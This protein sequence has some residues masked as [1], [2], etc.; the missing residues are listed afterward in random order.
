MWEDVLPAFRFLNRMNL[1][2]VGE[3]QVTLAGLL[4]AI[5]AAIVAV[6]AVRTLPGM[7]DVYVLSRF[8]MHDG[9]RSALVT[10]VRYFLVI[11]GVV[12][13]CSR[14]GATWANLHWIVAALGVGLGFGLQEIV[15]NLTSGLLLLLDGRIRPLD[16]VTV[17]DTSGRVTSI[18][19]LAT[20]VTDWNNRE[21]VIPN[22][23]FISGRVINWTLSERNVRLDVPVG[24]AYG[25]DTRKA[26]E[27]LVR[28]GRENEHTLDDPPVRA[29][30]LGFGASSLDFQL[31]AWV[32]MEDLLKTRHELHRAVDDAFH[33]AGIVIAF[34]QLD[35]HLD[36]P[37]E[38]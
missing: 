20:T 4:S 12:N 14:L 11:I 10:L 33:E 6:F 36:G 26:E 24:I 5:L 21:V 35:V 19:A 1:Y 3:V 31:H 7:L 27:I 2:T 29:V 15:A 22:K 13:V 32:N 9:E 28:V 17:G 38:I 25:S 37:V 23:E 30:F 34:P 16:V 18:R 8:A